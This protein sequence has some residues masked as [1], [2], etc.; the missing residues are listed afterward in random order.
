[1]TMNQTLGKRPV[2]IVGLPRSGTTWIGEVL[3][4]APGT[5]S[6]I[7]PDNE[8]LSVLAWFCKAGLPRFPY[9]AP[10]D[11][12]GLYQQLWCS[13][14]AGN[15]WPW[16]LNRALSFFI[17]IRAAELE[18]EVGERTGFVYTDRSMRTVGPAGK[19]KRY[20]VDAH[21]QMAWLARSL[22]A[23]SGRFKADH[24]AI[25]KSVH[26][27]LSIEWITA[28]YP[29]DVVVILRNPYSLYASYRRLRMPDGFRNLLFQEPLSRDR[30]QYLPAPSET[31]ML[32]HRDAMAFQIMLMYKIIESQVSRHPEWMLLSH[33]RLCMNPQEG[34]RNVFGKLDLSWSARTDMKIDALNIPGKGFDAKRVSKQQPTKWKT[35][36]SAEEQAIIE[37]WIQRFELNGF[38]EDFVNL[39]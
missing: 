2:L 26:A 34:Y 9:L 11:E 28:H 19:I 39:E 21:R 7:E 16:I 13:A 31:R 22:L 25:V 36:V 32:E 23:A 10:S 3:G 35:E 18:A 6:I 38:F 30:L 27:P 4:S 8:K 1:M 15:R 33:D 37:G 12:A 14:L 29:A 24:R 5:F 20:Q 17:K